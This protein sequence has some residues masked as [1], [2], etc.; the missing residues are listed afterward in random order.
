MNP[1]RLLLIL[2][3]IL[4]GVDLVVLRMI[5]HRRVGHWLLSAAALCAAAALLLVFVLPSK[6]L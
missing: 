4:V 2:A 5:L 1:A 6:A 3:V